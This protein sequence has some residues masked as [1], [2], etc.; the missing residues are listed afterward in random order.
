M[1]IV[2]VIGWNLTNQSV[3]ILYQMTP[4][5]NCKVGGVQNELGATE[6]P[7]F[8]VVAVLSINRLTSPIEVLYM[9]DLLSFQDFL[10]F[11]TP[12][13]SVYRF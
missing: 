5:F 12:D 9:F 13:P 10:P 4:D 11:L 6:L 1:H 2:V 7:I 3:I 8:I